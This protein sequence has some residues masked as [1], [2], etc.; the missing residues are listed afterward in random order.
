MAD[1]KFVIGIDPGLSGAVCV[2]EFEKEVEKYFN[3]VYQVRNKNVLTFNWRKAKIK[4]ISFFDFRQVKREKIKTRITRKDF[5]TYI[6]V[7]NFYNFIS[8][9]KHAYFFVERVHAMPT[10]STVSAF[11][12]G[13]LYGSV[14]SIL[15]IL[16][17]KIIDVPINW[18][19]LM[20]QF[21]YE[22]DPIIYKKI[23]DINVDKDDDL[24]DVE[25]AKVLLNM[26]EI[27]HENLLYLKKHHNRADSFLIAIW[28]LIGCSDLIVK[29]LLKWKLQNK[30]KGGG[31]D[32]I[33]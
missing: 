22:H 6:N 10:D 33:N 32:E 19:F 2:I 23:M 25:Y 20:T 11:K 24:Y 5:D 30:Q 18:R 9:Y 31:E 28:G 16:H 17:C 12:F 4:N 21:F 15:R 3:Y 13:V 14:Y 1:N 8:K 7:E 27:N 26:W 29:N